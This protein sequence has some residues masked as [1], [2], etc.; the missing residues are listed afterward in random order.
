MTDGPITTEPPQQPAPKKRNLVPWIFAGIGVVVAAAIAIPVS[1]NAT[2]EAAKKK[3]AARVAAEA[4]A[5]EVERLATFRGEL[6]SCGVASAGSSTVEI[7]DGGKGCAT[8]AGHE[9]GRSH[10]C[11]ALVFPQGSRGTCGNRSRDWSD[12]SPRWS[13]KRHMG[14]VC[15]FMGVPPGRRRERPHQTR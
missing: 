2:H 5:A 1:L 10:L 12:S 6:A 7:L 11:P 15:D 9:V 14:R 13:S 8:S 3:E 4:Q